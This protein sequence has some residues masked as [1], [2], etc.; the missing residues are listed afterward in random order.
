MAEDPP[1]DEWLEAANL[2]A[3]VAQLLS[4]VIHQVNN[5]LQTVGGHAELLKTDPGVTD[6]TRRRA[7][8]ITGVT[9]RTAE[10]LASFQIFTRP[11]TEPTVQSLKGVAERALAFRHYGLGRARIQAAVTG[12]A[13][14]MVRA[15]PRPLM[16]AVLNV[17]LNAE[18]ALAAAA[19]PQG[20]IDIDVTR[21]GERVLLT[22]SDNGPGP[23]PE[24]GE[25]RPRLG[26]ANRLGLG[27][28]MARR[29]VSRLGGELSVGP[30]SSGGTRVTMA[31][32]AAVD[33]P[34]TDAVLA[35]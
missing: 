8:T 28:R 23:V 12:D 24:P 21:A 30:G 16:Q 7:Q 1:Q 19:L 6:T 4:T 34:G 25:G 11:S 17:V 33:V 10:M 27:L 31:L 14:A 18:Q 32:P 5:A 22:V 26:P 35:G 13:A 9:D 3:T 2:H 20:R 15:E 29:I